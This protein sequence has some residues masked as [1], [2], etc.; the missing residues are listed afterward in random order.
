MSNVT[1]ERGATLS[2][3]GRFYSAPDSCNQLNVG[4]DDVRWRKNGNP[5]KFSFI[6]VG[7]QYNGKF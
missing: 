3:R 6:Y 2:G 4:L 1:W 5:K 7:L